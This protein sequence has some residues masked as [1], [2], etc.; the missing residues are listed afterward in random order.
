MYLTKSVFAYQR[1]DTLRIQIGNQDLP[2]RPWKVKNMLKCSSCQFTT[3]PD[4]SLLWM[5]FCDRFQPN[6]S[7]SCPTW[8]KFPNAAF[9]FT[10][11]VPFFLPYRTSWGTYNEWHYI[12]CH[13]QRR[14][15]DHWYP[16]ASK[17]FYNSDSQQARSAVSLRSPC[18]LRCYP[19]LSQGKSFLAT[20]RRY[21]SILS[22]WLR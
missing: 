1:D 7:F 5:L 22:H 2:I 19:T 10:Y 6:P 14:I 17:I 15:Q 20:S 11:L 13:I 21:I 16:R 18:Y 12:K 4:S 9:L 3:V 8:T